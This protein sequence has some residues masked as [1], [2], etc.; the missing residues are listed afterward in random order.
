MA[1]CKSEISFFS[2]AETYWDSLI[3]G[4]EDYKSR[5][6]EL[7]E[8][9]EQ[10]KMETALKDLGITT[11]HLLS[12]SESTF[13]SFQGNYLGL[14]QELYSGND[15]MIAMLQKFGGISADVLTPLS[16]TIS[17]TADKIGR[18]HV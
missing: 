1:S 15:E 18:A 5:W 11:E 12:M 16:D 3:K 17:D 6:Q 4:L 8:I 7:T 2:P 14:L 10:A 13:R 9:E